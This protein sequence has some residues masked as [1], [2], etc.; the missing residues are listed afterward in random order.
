MVHVFQVKFK[1]ITRL[2]WLASTI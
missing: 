1:D 2:T